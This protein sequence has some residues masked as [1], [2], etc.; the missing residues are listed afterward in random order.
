MNLLD[1]WSWFAS[2]GVSQNRGVDLVQCKLNPRKTKGQNRFGT[3]PHSS[4]L[5]QDFPPRTSL[6]TK[7][8]F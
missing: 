1:H 7:A 8:F 4:T 3:S 2:E 6:K 5:F